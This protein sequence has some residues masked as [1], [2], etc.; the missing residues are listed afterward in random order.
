MRKRRQWSIKKG[1]AS[2]M[3]TRFLNAAR[4]FYNKEDRSSWIPNWMKK[5]V[6]K[7]VLLEEEHEIPQFIRESHATHKKQ[8]DLHALK[9]QDD[10]FYQKSKPLPP[11]PAQN[12]E[13]ELLDIEEGEILNF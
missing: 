5:T 7:E 12:G 8:N 9:K 3:S 10:K 4:K 2:K 13:E 1:Q 6:K 11:I